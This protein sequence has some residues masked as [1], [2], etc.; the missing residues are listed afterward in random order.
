MAFSGSHWGGSSTKPLASYKLARLSAVGLFV[1]A[2]AGDG[3]R[4]VLNGKPT[5]LWRCAALFPEAAGEDDCA[6][7]LVR[8]SSNLQAI[9]SDRSI[10]LL[11]K[12]SSFQTKNQTSKFSQLAI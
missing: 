7:P 2:S 6:A 5:S 8:Y 9:T 11:A 1:R 12:L 10:A 4:D 3:S